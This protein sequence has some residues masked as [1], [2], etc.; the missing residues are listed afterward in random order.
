MFKNLI[1]YFDVLAP[2]LL[3]GQ[4]HGGQIAN[5]HITSRPPVADVPV[6]AEDAP[7]VAMREE[8]SAGTT[9]S[10]KRSFLTKVRMD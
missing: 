1:D 3:E 6:L 8:D 7:Q 9:N 2:S 10:Y 5:L 4:H